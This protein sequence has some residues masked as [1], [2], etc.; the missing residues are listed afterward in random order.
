VIWND[1]LE[2]LKIAAMSEACEDELFFDA[3]VVENGEL[4]VRIAAIGHRYQ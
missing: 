4:V 3:P 1:F 2:S